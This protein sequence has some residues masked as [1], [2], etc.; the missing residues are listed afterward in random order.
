M[1]GT[2]AVIL[3]G[4]KGE[5][6]W[7]ATLARPKP[8][9]PFGGNGRTLIRA[10]YERVLP[11]VGAEGIYLVATGELAEALGAEL[12]LPPEQLIL[13][14]Y[15]KNTAPAVGLAAL[16]LGARDPEGI[17][18]VLPADHRI[19][20]EEAFRRALR[21]AARAAEEG[22]LV[23]LGIR[24]TYPATGYGY[25]EGGEP[26]FTAEGYTVHRARRF[27][28][29]PDRATAEAYLSRGNFFWNS[30]IFI[31]RFSRILEEIERHLPG[32]AAGLARL[33]EHIGEPSFAEAVR[34]AYAGA[35]GTSIDYGVME[36]AERIATIPVSF[37]WSDLGDWHAIWEVSRKS[38]Q[39]NAAANAEL[40]ARDA[41]G[42]LVF[43]LTRKRVGL[44]GVDGL[45]V[46]DAPGALLVARRDRA[47]EVREIARAFAAR[48]HDW[49][50]LY[51]LDTG[52]MLGAIEGFPEQ[53]REALERGRSAGLPAGLKGFTRICVVGMGG[54][55]I[56][57]DLLGLALPGVEDIT[58]RD[59]RV[60]DYIGE[61]TLL[62][63]ASYSGNTEETLTAFLQGLGRTRRALGIS[64]GGKLRDLCRER[65]IPW[66]GIPGGFQPRAALGH[67]LFTL[68]G[69][70]EGL[71]LR[72]EGLEEALDVLS[73]MAGELSPRVSPNR[74]QELAARLWRKIPVIYGATGTTAPIAFRWRTQINENA[75]QPAFSAELPELC[76]NEIVGYELAGELFPGIVR[77]FLR[78]SRDHPRVALRVE[79]LRGVL[80]RRGL[81]FLELRGE[82]GGGLA[83]ALSL[84]YL[85]D[86][87]SAYLAL[88]NGVD[89][90]PVAPISELKDRLA[91]EPWDPA[92]GP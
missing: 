30:G 57:G 61:E 6:L 22:Y 86:W 28:E 25:I 74:A 26:L 66:I 1:A 21:A 85:G 32:L 27:V 13:E 78:T 49:P 80:R 50:E 75:K 62:I 15:G 18:V 84:L 3:A 38:P 56:T 14:P 36:K 69:A 35:E 39:G 64:S 63:G 45:A 9:L 5:R 83:Q 71:G 42:S 87:T 89:P 79:I 41:K 7:P 88:L 24:P 58:V 44:L 40:V 17:M 23:T 68:L 48:E 72:A 73:R 29:K 46:V 51:R 59:Y 91:R 37:G 82:G 90:T 60:P 43:S 53:C 70:L 65:G 47:Q 20:D 11:L 52:G 8:L 77:V 81:E 31:W 33:R 10:T 92:A 2:Y 4:G 54:S 12:G 67:L 55:A 16:L 76:H 19:E 34:A